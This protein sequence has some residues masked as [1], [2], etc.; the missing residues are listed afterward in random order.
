M[1]DPSATGNV[2]QTFLDR[3]TE[4]YTVL[5]REPPAGD[6]RPGRRNRPHLGGAAPMRAAQTI[7]IVNPNTTASMTQTVLAG[8]RQVAG[9][10]TRLVGSTAARGVES[11]E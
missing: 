11:V 10:S 8:A 3:N 7:M 2:A 6:T 4:L 1:L 5:P 9:P